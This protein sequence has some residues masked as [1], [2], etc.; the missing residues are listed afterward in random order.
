MGLPTDDEVGG[1]KKG[2]MIRGRSWLR[3]ET[4]DNLELNYPP[5]LKLM[6]FDPI[7]LPTKASRLTRQL[8]IIWWF[9]IFIGI[10]NLSNS[11]VLYIIDRAGDDDRPYRVSGGI[12]DIFLSILNLLLFPVSAFFTFCTGYRAVALPSR[13]EKM[14]F[15]WF[16][17][18]SFVCSMVFALKKIEI[19]NNLDSLNSFPDS[20]DLVH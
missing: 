18:M 7:S 10:V 11:I 19:E 4:R 1:Q 9:A 15:K 12:M 16:C 14:L 5:G 20:Y 13:D 8:Q 2:R 17:L 6:N 3:L